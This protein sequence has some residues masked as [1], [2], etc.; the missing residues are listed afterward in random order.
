MA[1]KARE[2]CAKL[3]GMSTVRKKTFSA[4]SFFKSIVGQV[5]FPNFLNTAPQIL[6]IVDLIG[7][8]SKKIDL[9]A[10]N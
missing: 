3:K 7:A 5:K 4:I 9:K 8:N 1:Q 2:P 6:S 10:S